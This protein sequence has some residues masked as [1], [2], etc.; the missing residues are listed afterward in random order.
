MIIILNKKVVVFLRCLYGKNNMS[1]DF[2]FSDKVIFLADVW[3]LS[4]LFHNTTDIELI[5][6][7]HSF[8]SSKNSKRSR[9]V[10]N[11]PKVWEIESFTAESDTYMKALVRSNISLLNTIRMIGTEKI[12]R[13]RFLGRLRKKIVNESKIQFTSI[14]QE[15]KSGR[16]L[17]ERSN[18]FP[19]KIHDLWQSFN[20]CKWMKI[21]SSAQC[22][23]CKVYFSAQLN[24]LR[25]VL[26]FKKI[27]SYWTY[28][29]PSLFECAENT[30]F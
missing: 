7:S 23:L 16:H 15:A 24:K 11:M 18:S 4:Y 1:G 9:I 30:L 28:I 25:P 12:V 6:I 22:V 19:I 17:F 26:K 14:F 13:E 3:W 2:I 20:K 29:C 8:W 27:L 5:V 21:C 10:I